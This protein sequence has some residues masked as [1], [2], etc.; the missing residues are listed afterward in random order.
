[1]KLSELVLSIVGRG[2]QEPGAAEG[3]GKTLVGM[4]ETC[5]SAWPRVA[6]ADDVFVRYLAERL[7][8]DQDPCVGLAAIHASDLYLACGCTVAD[9]AALAAFEQ[10]FTAN[11][12]G[13]IGRADVLPEFTDEVKQLVRERLFVAE[14]GLLPRI[15]GYTGRG[16]LGAWV[17][18][19]V[20]RVAVNLRKSLKS[21]VSVVHDALDDVPA[22]MRDPELAYLETHYREEFA[23]AFKSAVARLEAR[24][25][26]VLA[27]VFVNGAD[28]E[29]IGVLYGVSS[30]TV[31]RWVEGAREQILAETLSQLGK[32]LG[33]STEE[34]E[35]VI[36]LVQS[37][38]DVSILTALRHD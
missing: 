10:S 30:R 6:L 25:R 24:D 29:G 32:K 2:C 14:G 38:L 11:V 1:M 27:L 18:T 8:R 3:L 21:G 37:R 15:A 7:P 33:L 17:R 35:R 22:T 20:A 13:F 9:P 4:L 31:R 5:R 28:T 19:A 12:P 26:A 23:A 36:G 34:L 16:P